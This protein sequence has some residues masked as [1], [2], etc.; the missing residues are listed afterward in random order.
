MLGLK[1]GNKVLAETPISI[2]KWTLSAGLSAFRVP[3]ILCPALNS[4]SMR[5]GCILYIYISYNLM[6]K[7]MEQESRNVRETAAKSTTLLKKVDIILLRIKHQ[8]PHEHSPERLGQGALGLG[9]LV[10]SCYPRL[11]FFFITNVN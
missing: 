8:I 1:P 4:P 6:P 7:I 3:D 5:Q 2:S 9:F 10:V 11:R